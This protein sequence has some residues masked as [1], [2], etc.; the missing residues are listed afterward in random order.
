[1][2]HGLVCL[3]I[4]VPI[5]HAAAGVRQVYRAVRCYCAHRPGDELRQQQA[6]Q[7]LVY[8]PTSQLYD[9][10]QPPMVGPSGDR[11]MTEASY[12]PPSVTAGS[13]VPR[14]EQIQ[15]TWDAGRMMPVPAPS[16][17]SSAFTKPETVPS[18]ATTY[19]P[20]QMPAT[21][22][23]SGILSPNVVVSQ[24]RDQDGAAYDNV[25]GQTANSD[26]QRYMASTTEYY[27]SRQ[28]V[29]IGGQGMGEN[30][31][32]NPSGLEVNTS[33]IPSARS[34]SSSALRQPA[35]T[36]G[37]GKKT[38]TFHENIATEY[39]IRQSYGS[40][41]S[42]SSFVALSPPEISTGYDSAMYHGPLGTYGAQ[43]PR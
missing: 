7:P 27:D 30:E 25:Q 12:C 22:Q 35:S 14:N 29:N 11:W 5:I 20:Y 19:E 8:V 6:A 40:T 37:S 34:L 33:G 31:P 16:T 38:V 32:E 41:S 23:L 17:M 1:M 24:T 9:N 4:Y 2:H 15:Q 28:N 36:P 21:E 13:V 26:M 42:D 10:R 43:A 3:P 18:M 39:A